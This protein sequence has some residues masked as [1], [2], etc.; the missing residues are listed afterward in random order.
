MKKAVI[1][2]AT[3]LPIFLLITLLCIDNPLA[4][5]G[6][7]AVAPTGVEL[8]EGYRNWAVISASHRTD[9]G[10]IRLILGN[11]IAIEAF[12]KGTLPFPD[13]TIIAKLA[14]KA[15]KHA[16]WES[17]L[18]P[19]KPMRQEFMVKDSKKYADTGGWGFGRF[20][21]GKPVEDTKVYASC[22]P[23]HKA[24]ASSQDFVFTRFAP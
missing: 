19:G 17:A 20:V 10:E 21:D 8:P 9:K 15:E 22:F 1:I 7:K 6:K 24:R 23:C 3:F 16:A 5:E 14:Y 2:V 18:V 11:D 12:K 13:G 4:G